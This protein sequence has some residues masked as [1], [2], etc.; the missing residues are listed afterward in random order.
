M[1]SIKYENEVLPEKKYPKLMISSNAVV[2][3]ESHGKGVAVHQITDG[4]HFV[5]HITN[6]WVMENFK[7]F[8]GTIEL[9]N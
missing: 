9:S 7:D 6:S 3:F 1:K 2:L 8:N 5:G 4:S